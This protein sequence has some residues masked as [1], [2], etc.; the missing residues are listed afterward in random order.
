MQCIFKSIDRALQNYA[1]GTVCLSL[2]CVLKNGMIQDWFC[3]PQAVGVDISAELRKRY[4]LHII[5][6][7]DM[8][9]TVLGESEKD[10]RKT[11]N[12]VTVQ[13]GHNGIGVGE[14]INGHVLEGASGF[15]GEVSYTNDLRKNITRLLLTI[16]IRNTSS[17]ISITGLTI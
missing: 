13:F 1:V 12:I 6:Q 16:P 8:K 10:R 11:K 2:P 9:L 7:N 5:V 3:N 15:A 4:A 14:M 17:V